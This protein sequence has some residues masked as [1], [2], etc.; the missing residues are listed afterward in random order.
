[1]LESLQNDDRLVLRLP[2]IEQDLLD[3][4]AFTQQIS[5]PTWQVYADVVGASTSELRSSCNQAALVAAGW[6][7]CKL[8]AAT[9]PPFDLL[10]G[11]LGAR[12]TQLESLP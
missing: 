10:Q 3:E 6:I 12:I 8:R 2:E 1:M 9:S 5:E 4:L 11:D 7:K